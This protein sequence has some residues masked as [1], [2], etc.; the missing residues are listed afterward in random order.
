[1]KFITR[2]HPMGDINPK[3]STVQSLYGG[4]FI[5]GGEENE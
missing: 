3:K 1:M 2:D 4:F 5:F